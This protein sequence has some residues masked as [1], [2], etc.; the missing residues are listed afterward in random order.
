MLPPDT[1]ELVRGIFDDFALN[2][3]DVALVELTWLAI[4][5]DHVICI[6][7]RGEG[8]SGKDFEGRTGYT[9]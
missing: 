3:L 1:A 8:K 5:E 2:V 7:F 4:F 9:A 6:F